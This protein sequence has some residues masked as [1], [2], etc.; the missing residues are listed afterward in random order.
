MEVKLPDKVV[1]R[2]HTALD[3]LKLDDHDRDNVR[4]F[5]VVGLDLFHAGSTKS[6]FGG[7]VG[8][9]SNY[10]Y[11]NKDQIERSEIMLKTESIRWGS[12]EGQ[13]LEHALVLAEDEQ[14]FGI[15]REILMTNTY[16]PA[17]NTVYPTICTFFMYSMGKYFN[18]KMQL[19]NRPLSMRLVLYS[20][21]SGFGYGLW[22]L[23]R[24]GTQHYYEKEADDT[25]AS[26][27][28][29]VANA[30]VRFYEKQLE[31]NISIRGLSGDHSVYTAKGNLTFLFRN[32][33]VPLTE[34]KS[35]FEKKLM[36]L[37][38]EG[39][40]EKRGDDGKEKDQ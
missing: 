38:E 10:T 14:V 23:L 33:H 17:L 37:E 25:L 36:E 34:R 3:I 28:P 26:L 32:R 29:E 39:E 22:A 21:L 1:R 31:K 2:F 12:A 30:G 15:A 40:G 6:K 5:T 7:L 4:A 16:Q 13:K 35:F 8:I 20:I 27:G 24:D 19:L 11:D 9:P 18:L